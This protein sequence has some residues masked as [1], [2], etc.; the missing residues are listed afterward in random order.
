MVVRTVLEAAHKAGVETAQLLRAAGLTD[1]ILRDPSQQILAKFLDTLLVEGA[2]MSGRRDF[3]LMASRFVRPGSMDIVGYTAMNSPTLQEANQRLSRYWLLIANGSALEQT[4]NSRGVILQFFT[5][6]G[7]EEA[8][9]AW[10]EFIVG[11]WLTFARWITDSDISPLQVRFPYPRVEYLEEYERMF[12]CP[13]QFNKHELS[14]VLGPEALN[15]PLVLRNE[16]LYAEFDRIAQETLDS[17]IEDGNYL[18]L[19]RQHLVR[20]CHDYKPMLTDVAERMHLSPRTLQRKLHDIGHTFTAVRD[21]TR[22]LGALSHLRNEA[23]AIGEAA[24]LCGYATNASFHRAVKRWTGLTPA[25]YRRKHLIRAA[26]R[27]S[28]SLDKQDRE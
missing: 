28:T 20:S 6:R 13:L 11:G 4:P 2:R 7:R 22:R 17:F 9:V 19:V 1:W 15:L 23:L 10:C 16:M 5:P 27:L 12:H 3:G 8:Y 26:G 21:E 14:V 18:S 24:F 25:A